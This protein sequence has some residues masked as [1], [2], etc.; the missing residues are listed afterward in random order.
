MNYLPGCWKD[1][2]SGQKKVPSRWV[3]LLA[4]RVRRRTSS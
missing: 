2:E 3:T 1:W 4:E